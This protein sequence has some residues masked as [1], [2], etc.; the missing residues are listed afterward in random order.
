MVIC[1]YYM[2]STLLIKTMLFIKNNSFLEVNIESFDANA[3]SH[4][5]YAVLSCGGTGRVFQLDKN[6]NFSGIEITGC[7]AKNGL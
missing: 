5:D 1:D 4:L 6:A 2:C 3:T 7:G